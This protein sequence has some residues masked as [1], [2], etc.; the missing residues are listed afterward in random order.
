MDRVLSLHVG[1]IAAAYI[2]IALV[3]PTSG[4]Y[5]YIHHPQLLVVILESLHALGKLL[6]FAPAIFGVDCMQQ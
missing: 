4:L 2:I 1:F 5:S 6:T 3:L